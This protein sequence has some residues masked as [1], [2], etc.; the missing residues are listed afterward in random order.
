MEQ[1]DSRGLLVARWKHAGTTNSSIA[2]R[3]YRQGGELISL[4]GAGVRRGLGSSAPSLSTNVVLDGALV[5]EER[6][7][8]CSGLGDLGSEPIG[9]VVGGWMRRPVQFTLDTAIVEWVPLLILRQAV[10]TSGADFD[11]LPRG[12]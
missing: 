10:S 12:S 11:Q 2:V 3:S 1:D 7:R 9:R 6:C 8:A 4:P 5:A